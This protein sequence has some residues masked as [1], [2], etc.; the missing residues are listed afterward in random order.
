MAYATVDDL[1]AGWR[2]LTADEQTRAT[3]LIGRASTMLEALCD[4]TSKSADILEIVVCSMVQRVMVAESA[5]VSAESM[6]AGGYSQSWTYSNP[7]GDMYL[8]KN[9][10]K[11]LGIGASWA[12]GAVKVDIHDSG[13]DSV[14]W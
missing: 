6:G 4:T 13:G 10:K 3:T 14:V 9:E 8:T 1:Q 12:A 2:T 7:S 11:M 5:G